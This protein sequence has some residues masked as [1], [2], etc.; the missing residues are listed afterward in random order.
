M[1]EITGDKIRTKCLRW[2]RR[3]SA[4]GLLLGYAGGMLA[5]GLV[6]E[7]A[8]DLPSVETLKQP[9]RPLSV[10]FVDRQGRDILVRGAHQAR[11]VKSEQLPQHLVEAVLAT[12][13][14]RF[15][16]HTGVDPIGL[17]RAMHANIQAGAWVQGGSTLSQQLVKNVF[18]TPDKTIRRKVQEAMLAVWLEHRFSKHEI[19]EK[20][21]NRVYFG[22]GTWGLEAAAQT[23]FDESVQ[24][25]DLGQSAL[26]IGLLKAPTRFNPASNPDAAGTRTA[27]VLSSM[28]DAGYID[29]T[30]RQAALQK[31][32]RIHRSSELSSANYFIDW[33][34]DDIEDAIGIPSRDIVVQTTLDIDAQLAAESAV[35]QHLDLDRG[36][37][38]AAVL[39]LAGDGG[40][41][42][43]VGGASYRDSQF[44]RVVS[45]RRQPGSA[46]KPFVYQAAFESGLTP[47]DWRTDEPIK[48]GDW[49]P[50]NFNNRFDGV[51][52]LETAYKRSVNTVAVRLSEDLGRQPVIDTAAKMGL[53]D[54][55][56]LRSLPLGAQDTTLFSLTSAYL[57]YANWGNRV[58]PY[59]ILSISTATGIP[60]YDFRKPERHKVL[61]SVHLGHMN[62]IMRET[63]VSGTGRAAR[64]DG[65][66]V[67]GKTGTTNDYRDAWFMGYV[68]DL[69]T[70]VWTGNDDNTAMAK[71]TGGQIPARIWH[72]MMTE[73]LAGYDPAS[74]PISEKPLRADNG[75]TLDVLLN[76]LETAL[77]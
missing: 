72:D 1:P 6:T 54:L 44:N 31:P 76:D 32:I 43:M 10:Q 59:G 34:W 68:P 39:T 21:L 57:P 8:Y 25:L 77:P 53:S 69:V 18:L 46:F 71:V 62:R 28:Q 58:E 64:I 14:R 16:Y 37:A 51:M 24:D 52:T 75:D 65:W 40:V 22:A 38:Q 35:R 41:R 29:R 3:G 60:L 11:N 56:P 4:L 36:A 63:I 73:I 26:L 5:L 23:Y 12:E 20:Y 9:N 17:T 50:G 30:Q 70:G 13:D 61:A 42:V 66:D 45:A 19:L 48:V 7:A 47:W 67:A 2:L 15:F 27:I 55:K 74:L 49:E 33:I